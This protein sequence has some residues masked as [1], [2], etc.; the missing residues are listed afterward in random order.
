[1]KQKKGVVNGQVNALFGFKS[2][3]E[4][5]VHE[6]DDVS[7]LP[8]HEQVGF[9]PTSKGSKLKS[10][11]V[12]LQDD[13]VCHKYETSQASRKQCDHEDLFSLEHEEKNC[14]LLAARLPDEEARLR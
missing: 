5:R 11:D 8:A 10:E 13:I 4:T 3:G 12:E 7:H 9:K 1:M 6:D 14:T 2:L